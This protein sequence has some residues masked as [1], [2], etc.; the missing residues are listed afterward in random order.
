MGERGPKPKEPKLKV[1][2]PRNPQRP[3]PPKGMNAK[4]R[5]VWTKVVNAYPV[6]HFKP[7][8][9]DLLRMYCGS[10]V[11]HKEA[12]AEI[13]K[14]GSVITQN[15]GITKANPYVDVAFKAEAS[16]TRLATKLGITVNNTTVNRGI[17]GSVTKPKSKREGLIF[18]G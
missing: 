13:F 9:S 18:N 12:E 15:N 7:Q 5:A 11:M 2:K 10:C 17:K 4:A 6:D 16:A 1:V 8:H 3:S 14:K